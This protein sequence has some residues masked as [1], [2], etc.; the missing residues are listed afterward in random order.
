[1]AGAYVAKPAVV[2]PFDGPPGWNIEWPFPGPLPPGYIP[3]YSMSFSADALY[4]PGTNTSQVLASFAD[5]GTFPTSQPQGQITW[6]ATLLGSPVQLKESTDL[7][8]SSSVSTAAIQSGGFWIGNPTLNFSVSLA[9]SGQTIV[10]T[11]SSLDPGGV[12]VEQSANIV[13]AGGVVKIISLMTPTLTAT[14][15]SSAECSV[16]ISD[17]DGSGGVS[18]A[19]DTVGGLIPATGDGGS[20]VAEVPG[21]N[22]GKVTLEES[23]AEKVYTI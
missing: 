20:Y 12:S 4:V 15:N 1:M 13:V 5:H 2:A 18:F 22:T 19:Y 8:F 9:N 3:I 6:T 21:G 16:G 23:I 17:V 11:A 14:T 10:L 7:S